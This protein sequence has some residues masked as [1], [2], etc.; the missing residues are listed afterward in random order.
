V[1]NADDNV[2]TSNGTGVS[3]AVGSTV[4][5]SL[6]AVHRNGTGLSNSAT[7]QTCSNNRNYGNTT[8]LSGAVVGVP[9]PGSCTQ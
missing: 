9:A 6:N 5:L 2:V 7:M 8:D 1:L 3:S 4:R